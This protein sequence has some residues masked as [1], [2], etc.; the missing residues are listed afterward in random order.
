MGHYIVFLKSDAIY[1]HNEKEEKILF[2]FWLA[3]KLQKRLNW[4]FSLGKDERWKA[5]SRKDKT[6]DEQEINVIGGHTGASRSAEKKIN[7]GEMENSVLILEV[8][9][10]ES[11]PLA[12][13]W[14]GMKLYGSSCARNSMESTNFTAS[15]RHRD[16]LLW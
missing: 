7:L 12:G 4:F 15:S 8:I 5:S 6:E 10:Y 1:S 16:S 11:R 13:E 9:I 2:N 3:E 14:R